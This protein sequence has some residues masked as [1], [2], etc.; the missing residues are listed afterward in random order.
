MGPFEAR[1]GLARILKVASGGWGVYE[2]WVEAPE[3]PCL[4]LDWDEPLVDYDIA[5]NNGLNKFNLIAKA[6]TGKIDDDGSQQLIDQ[7][8]DT[9]GPRSLK[10]SI[11]TARM[12]DPTLGGAVTTVLVN[13]VTNFGATTVGGNNMISATFHIG[14]WGQ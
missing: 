2:R 1:A 12:T 9:N 10:K 14:V 13:G 4:I 8:I 11:E 5:M 6:L 7:L 3:P